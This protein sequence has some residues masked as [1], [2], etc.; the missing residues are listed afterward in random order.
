M[1]RFH[2]FSTFRL[3]V[4][5]LL[6]LAAT[7][8]HAQDAVPGTLLTFDGVDD[9]AFA[10][11]DLDLGASDITLEAWVRRASSGTNDF[12]F[13]YGDVNE[14]VNQGLSM[15]F[16]P[17]NVFAFGFAGGNDLDTPDMYTDTEWHHWAG[18]Y[19]RTNGTRTIYR[20]GVEVAS[21]A[22]VVPFEE[23]PDPELYLGRFFLQNGSDFGG[24]MEE[25][26][27]WSTARTETEIREA[28]HR[29]MT[30][31]EPGLVAYWQ[32][33]EGSGTTAGD[34]VGGHDVGLQNGMAWATSDV[35]VAGG[36][37]ATA[38]AALDPIRGVSG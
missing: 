1:K 7:S 20:D 27:V 35:P 23:V 32:F 38:T 26:R 2:L 10:Q 4:G 22:G 25:L 3:L 24:S 34:V 36:A 14:G 30:G 31:A 16:R 8:V 6:W 21:D 33:N 37:S 13:S 19:D 17:T 18:V 12:F 15:G 5:A 29:T 9:R 28:M 11:T